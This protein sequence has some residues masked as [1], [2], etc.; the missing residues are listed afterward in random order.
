MTAISMRDIKQCFYQP[1][2]PGIIDAIHPATGLGL[3][4]KET[5]EQVRERNPGAEVG[6]FDEVC[7]A[8]A[9]YW[10]KPPTE[11][12]EA[13][14]WEMLCVLPPEGWEIRDDSESFKLCEYTS[15]AVTGIYARIGPVGQARYFEMQDYFTLPHAVIV[16]RCQAETD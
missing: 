15:G 3:Y 6:D 7:D 13:R 5:L 14:F 11:I 1:G 2:K 10:R 16:E 8:Q 12:T 9:D 4:S